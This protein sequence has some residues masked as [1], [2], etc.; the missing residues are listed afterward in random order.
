[1]RVL[2]EAIRQRCVEEASPGYEDAGVR[3]LCSEG[4]WEAA[5]SAVQGLDLRPLVE[6]ARQSA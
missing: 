4:C 2:A 1:M 3:G 6:E 5:V